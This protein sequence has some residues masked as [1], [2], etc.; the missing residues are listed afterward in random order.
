MYVTGWSR[1]PEPDWLASL[2]FKSDGY[3]TAGNLE[4]PDVDALVELGAS[5]YEIEERKRVYNEI[6][7]TVLDEAW[8]VPLLY[9]VHYAAAPKT[10]GNLDLLMGW[11]G[12]MDVS[13]I[14]LRGER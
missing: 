6:N 5:L 14:Y 8:V 3:Y 11:D 1:Y 7:R 10:V 9:G 2:A 12:K 4:R 13:R